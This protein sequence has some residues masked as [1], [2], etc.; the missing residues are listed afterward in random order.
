MSDVRIRGLT[1]RW[2][3]KPPDDGGRRSRP[4]RSRRASSS[5]CSVR[6]AAARRR[7][8]AASPGSRPPNTGEIT[9]GDDA[10]STPA[11]EGQRAAEQARHRHG[12]PVLRALAAHDRAQEHRLPAAR[13]AASIKATARPWVEETAALVD[14]EPLLDRYPGAAE[15]RPAAAR[16]ARPRPRRPARARPV[17]R[18][19][20]QPRRPAARPGAHRDPRA[21]QPP[22]LHRR[23][24]HP[25][26]VGGARP[27]RPARDHARRAASSSSARP[28]RS[29]R[30]PRPSTSPASSACRTGFALDVTGD[31]AGRT[32]A[33]RLGASTAPRRP[34]A[35]LA[36]RPLHEP[37]T[38]GSTARRGR[39]RPAAGSRF[40]PSSS[41]PSSAGSSWTS[42]STVG[43]TRL[44][45][46]SQRA[47]A[48]AGPGRSTPARASAVV[49]SGAT[50]RFFDEA[51]ARVMP[52]AQP[53]SAPS[54]ALRR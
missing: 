48:A 16:R 30:S 29:S 53:P 17:R 21:A 18:A 39:S 42:S 14:C 11:A 19:A 2:H 26:P 25:R 9:F 36:R 35:R 44:R 31:G 43:D 5:S 28:R 1:K 6:A 8:C 12:L 27:R 52:L 23:V 32:T 22:R 45:A 38:S 4:R 47:S 50:P 54:G 49:R 51:G 34:R 10:S 13:P 46:A 20:E 40:P 15:R 3:G 41:T 24:R 33:S 37:R 7:R